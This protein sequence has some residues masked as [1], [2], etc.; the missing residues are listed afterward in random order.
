MGLIG[1]IV[2]ESAWDALYTIEKWQQRDRQDR[3]SQQLAVVEAFTGPFLVSRPTVGLL[4]LPDGSGDRIEWCLAFSASVTRPTRYCGREAQAPGGHHDELDKDSP[5]A[6]LLIRIC[7]I[8]SNFSLFFQEKYLFI[9][10]INSVEFSPSYLARGRETPIIAHKTG[11][12]IRRSVHLRCCSTVFCRAE[13]VRSPAAAAAICF[14]LTG[15]GGQW[16]P[17]DSDIYAQNTCT[18]KNKM[19]ILSF[20]WIDCIS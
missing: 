20:V 6:A 15:G 9:K 17:I 11:R 7:H 16:T 14:M 12:R 8:R 19:G 4:K 5:V 3:P 10:K 2:A 1:K 18:E 13:L